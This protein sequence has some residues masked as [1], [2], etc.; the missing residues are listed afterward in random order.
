[1][2][3]ALHRVRDAPA[4][5]LPPVA[6]RLNVGFCRYYIA[7]IANTIQT[8]C[9][10]GSSDRHIELIERGKMLDG[11]VTSTTTRWAVYR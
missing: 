7:C 1:M 5:R 6:V 3:P 2:G 10:G 11:K 8:A 9:W 4:A